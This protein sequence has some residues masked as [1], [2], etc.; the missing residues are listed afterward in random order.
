MNST[1]P[2][3]PNSIFQYAI[4]PSSNLAI[5][6]WYV[7]SIAF[8]PETYVVQYQE[9]NEDTTGPV[10]TTMEIQGRK[11]ISLSNERYQTIIEELSPGTV[12][13]FQIV[14]NNPAGTSMTPFTDFTTQ[15]PG[16]LNLIQYK[17]NYSINH[18]FLSN[19][20]I[21]RQCVSWSHFSTF[22]SN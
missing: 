20:F 14:S 15:T 1:G 6:E 8:T 3:P 5:V 22:Q 16:W 2:S 7:Q 4:L 17:H 21:C 13:S 10:M 11:N 19:F 18:N 12:Y 9:I